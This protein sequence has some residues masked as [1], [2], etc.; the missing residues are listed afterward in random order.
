[1]FMRGCEVLI[2]LDRCNIEVNVA[3]EKGGGYRS[4]HRWG[5]TVV[6][7]RVDGCG[8][9]LIKMGFF[10]ESRRKGAAQIDKIISMLYTLNYRTI[11]GAEI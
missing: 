8:H 10:P 4:C 6:F 1:M 2:F 3:D 9:T 11:P 5:T 7:Y